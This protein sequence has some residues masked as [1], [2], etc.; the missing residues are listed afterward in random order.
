MMQ[1]YVLKVPVSDSRKAV[2]AKAKDALFMQLSGRLREVMQSDGPAAAID[3]CSQEAVKIA[4]S[5]GKEHGVA[6]GRTSYKLRNPA[7]AP[8]DW[9]TPFVDQRTNTRRWE[10]PMMHVALGEEGMRE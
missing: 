7:N 2:A 9:V 10:W 5:V 8:R 6:I 4:E 1:Q 3:V